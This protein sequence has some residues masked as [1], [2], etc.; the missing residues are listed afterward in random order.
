M[1]DAISVVNG[2]ATYAL[3][4]GGAAVSPES[5]SHVLCS[6]NGILQKSGSSFSISSSNIVFASNLATG[7]VIDFVMLLGSVLN[8]GTVSDATITNAKLA[9]DIISGETE[10]ASAPADTDELLISDAGTLKRIDYSLIKA[11]VSPSFFATLGSH[12]AIPTGTETVIAVNTESYDDGGCYNNTSGAVTLN[13]I[14]VPAYS[15]CPN[16]AGK[17]LVVGQIQDLTG[18]GAYDILYIYKNSASVS[19]IQNQSDIGDAR[20]WNAAV[21]VDLNG[22]G[23]DVNIRR[24]HNA[25]S[26]KSTYGNDGSTF[27]GAFRLLGV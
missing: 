2:Q 5:S 15:F 22:T 13:G 11:S 7:D 12:Q 18:A 1:C 8:V 16:V 21:I 26:D 20:T 24:Y 19:T 17:Y 3:Q 14:S 4:V 23:D 10:L 9:Q 6:L 25:G 27:F